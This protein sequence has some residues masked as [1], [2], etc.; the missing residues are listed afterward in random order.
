L[1]LTKVE[2]SRRSAPRWGLL[3]DGRLAASSRADG[4]RRRR[5][6]RSC[7]VVNRRSPGWGAVPEKKPLSHAQDST[8]GSEEEVVWK[9]KREV[10]DVAREGSKGVLGA[11]GFEPP[12][13]R[14]GGSRR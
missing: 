14:V 5:R 6:S 11:A 4:G 2:S 8:N 13:A 1:D 7:S 10:P 9:H 3:E 12:V